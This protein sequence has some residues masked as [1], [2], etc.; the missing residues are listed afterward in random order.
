MDDAGV[1]KNVM[2]KRAKGNAAIGLGFTPGVAYLMRPRPCRTLLFHPARRH[3]RCRAVSV[4][5]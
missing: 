5:L 1:R 3:R 4:S 2:P